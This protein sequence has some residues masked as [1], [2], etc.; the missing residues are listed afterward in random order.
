[1]SDLRVIHTS[2]GHAPDPDIE[3][4]L[5]PCDGDAATWLRAEC[6]VDTRKLYTAQTAYPV[7]LHRVTPEHGAW[8]ATMYRPT[9]RER[10]AAWWDAHRVAIVRDAVLTVSFIV[11]IIGGALVLHAFVTTL[12]AAIAWAWR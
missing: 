12:A 1:M 5:D 8:P 7:E 6:G 9:R 10:V 3:R 11:A 2:T 4:R